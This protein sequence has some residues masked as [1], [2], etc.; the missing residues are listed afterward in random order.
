[1]KAGN[2][3]EADYPAIQILKSRKMEISV[4]KGIK[5]PFARNQIFTKEPKIQY[6]IFGF[7]VPGISYAIRSSSKKQCP[8]G[9][10]SG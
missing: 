10:K 7:F 3:N 6:S 8:R 2:D 9:I 4:K 1:M 5:S